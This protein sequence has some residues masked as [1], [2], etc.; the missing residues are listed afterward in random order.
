M[1]KK[2]IYFLTT[3]FILYSYTSSI[4]A[5]TSASASGVIS[6]EN[7]SGYSPITCNHSSADSVINGTTFSMSCTIFSNNNINN[8]SIKSTNGGQLLNEANRYLS[9]RPYTASYNITVF[10]DSIV[11]TGLDAENNLVTTQ[12]TKIYDINTKT[13]GRVQV[14]VIG[15]TV[16]ATFTI[17]DGLTFGDT[18]DTIYVGTYSD[19]IFLKVLNSDI[20]QGF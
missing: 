2:T 11:D 17:E 9:P 12:Y 18:T 19:T 6:K 16:N 8:I 10:Q 15:V 7:A 4:F 20:S 14:D 1:I 13:D 3:I 5:L